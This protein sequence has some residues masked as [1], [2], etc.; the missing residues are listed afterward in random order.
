MY[1]S[2]FGFRRRPFAALPDVDGFVPLDGAC[3]AFSS[4]FQCVQNGQGIAVLTA[5]AGL[6]K[7]LLCRRLARELAEAFQVV[8]LSSGN[9]LTRRALLQSVLYELGYSY[10]RM[11]DQELRLE[12][13]SALR[14]LPPAKGGLV[15]IVDEAHLLAP[16]ML[17][18]LRTWTNVGHEGEPL[19]RLVASGQL[20]LEETLSHPAL[21]DFNQRIG[22]HAMLEPLS[23]DES[24]SYIAR[25]LAWAG[26]NV[27]EVFSGAALAAICDCSDG[28]PRCIHQLADHSLLLAY[29]S[30]QK[31]VPLDTVREALDDLKQLPL[32]WNESFAVRQPETIIEQARSSRADAEPVIAELVRSEPAP[33]VLAASSRIETPPPSDAD[34]LV[35]VEFGLPEPAN[36]RPAV[37]P[38]CPPSL[39]RENSPAPRPVIAGPAT[40]PLVQAP[41]VSRVD[42]VN[43]PA[44]GVDEEIV[45]DRYAALDAAVSRLT[46]TMLSVQA[47][48]RRKE[49]TAAAVPAPPVPASAASSVAARPSAQRSTIPSP[50]QQ[51]PQQLL[52]EPVATVVYDVILPE[53]VIACS[54]QTDD[55]SLVEPPLEETVGGRGR[56]AMTGEEGSQPRRPYERL[57]SELRRRRVGV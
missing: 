10:V 31:P 39:V 9:F 52:G 40:S 46:R 15:I 4:L 55:V 13:T 8:F 56:E 51:P 5:P 48:S 21:A 42:V 14:R 50:P 34:Q 36:E 12:L 26:A 38:A 22:C 2:F 54:E 45:I 17:E 47:S 20:S 32:T 44:A 28:S 24:T 23:R 29:L 30:N 6:G 37:A 43:P 49:S 11:G 7:T 25:R 35:A 33:T 41:P 27:S 19:V 57:F 3:R 1:E 53:D 16:R 18:E